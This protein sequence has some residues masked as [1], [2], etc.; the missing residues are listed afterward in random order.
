MHPGVTGTSCCGAHLGRPFGR[1]ARAFHLSGAGGMSVATHGARHLVHALSSRR[2]APAPSCPSLHA[3]SRGDHPCAA[4][5]HGVCHGWPA[6]RPQSPQTACACA[7]GPHVWRE[8]RCGRA[9]RA[10]A[11]VGRLTCAGAVGQPASLAASAARG[12]CTRCLE[13]PLHATTCKPC[14]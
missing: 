3:L 8:A 14:S 10:R 1:R 6:A 11:G 7:W 2:L 9:L 4:C 5:A 13:G 12:H